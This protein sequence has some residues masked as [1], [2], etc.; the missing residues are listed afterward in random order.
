MVWLSHCVVSNS[1][2][3]WV[4]ENFYLNMALVWRSSC[5]RRMKLA[6]MLLW[7]SH[8]HMDLVKMLCH[9]Y[10]TIFNTL[11]MLSKP[12]HISL[13]CLTA[14][15]CYIM[16]MGHFIQCHSYFAFICLCFFRLWHTLAHTGAYYLAL[17]PPLDACACV[18][19][20][21]HF[22]YWRLN[23]CSFVWSVVAFD[24]MLSVLHSLSDCNVI[25]FVMASKYW[26]RHWPITKG[27]P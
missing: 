13:G 3:S 23:D 9:Y 1:M 6:T 11:P 12:Q 22:Y 21:T 26:H 24:M 17:S 2:A 7:I 19:F 4:W 10:L 18:S 25:C 20:H 27:N 16:P 5:S 15:L 8:N 14:E